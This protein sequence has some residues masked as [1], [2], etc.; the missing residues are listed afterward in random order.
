MAHPAAPPRRLQRKTRWPPQLPLPEPL[1]LEPEVSRGGVND[2][3]GLPRW[4]SPPE[5]WR[6]AAMVPVVIDSLPK[7]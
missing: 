5:R 7:D 3:L 1:A 2:G 4:A 6:R